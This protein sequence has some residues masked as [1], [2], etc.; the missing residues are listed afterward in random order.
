MRDLCKTP[1]FPASGGNVQGLSRTPIWDL[2]TTL[3]LD[4]PRRNTTS[5]PL[6]ARRKGGLDDAFGFG[7]AR[8]T[9]LDSGFLRNDGSCAKNLIRGT[10]GVSAA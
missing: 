6:F 10:K 9:L 4:D 3:P 8:P 1:G 2:C 7:A 5:L